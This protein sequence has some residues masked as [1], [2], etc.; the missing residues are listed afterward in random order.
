MQHDAWG[1]FPRPD[2]TCHRAQ[3]SRSRMSSDCDPSTANNPGLSAHVPT[4]A[5]LM[6]SAL[7]TLLHDN[8]LHREKFPFQP[9]RRGADSLGVHD[10][11]DAPLVID[12]VGDILAHILLGPVGPHAPDPKGFLSAQVGGLAVLLTRLQAEP[13]GELALA[14]KPLPLVLH[15]LVAVLG[16]R[17]QGLTAQVGER[18][19]VPASCGHQRPPAKIAS[20]TRRRF[21]RGRTLRN[22]SACALT[23]SSCAWAASGEGSTAGIVRIQSSN[24]RRAKTSCTSIAVSGRSFA[25][26]SGCGIC[27]VSGGRAR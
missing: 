25:G 20:K 12:K 9:I 15:D 1:Y 22:T 19:A 27:G 3:L 2:W 13:I 8:A 6:V 17:L 7:S 5:R 4:S 21:R 11:P 14:V 23:R 16:G 26:A 18:H 24:L 10:M